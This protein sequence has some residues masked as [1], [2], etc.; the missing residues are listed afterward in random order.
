MK[1]VLLFIGT[2][3]A[4]LVVLSIVVKLLG[5]DQFLYANGINYLSLLAFAAVFGFGGHSYRWPFPSGWPSGAPA[6]R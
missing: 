6:R 3:I 2:N 5:V 1:R 4:V